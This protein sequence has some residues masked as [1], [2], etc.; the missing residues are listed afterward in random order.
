[1]CNSTHDTTERLPREEIGALST[2]INGKDETQATRE[3][4]ADLQPLFENK[5]GHSFT[6]AVTRLPGSQL[7]AKPN[8][9]TK[10]RA[11]RKIQ[12]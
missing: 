12:R 8:A 3:I 11:K 10:K 7:Q 5:Y 9:V 1:M 6:D 4:L 2:A